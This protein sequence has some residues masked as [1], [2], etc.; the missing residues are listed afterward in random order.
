MT[1]LTALYL[2]N[3]QITDITPLAGMTGLTVLRLHDNQITDTWPLTGMTDLTWL[4][5]RNNQITDNQIRLLRQ[6][7]PNCDIDSNN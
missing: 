6:T 1:N 7:M 5:L 4:S 3:N 2:N